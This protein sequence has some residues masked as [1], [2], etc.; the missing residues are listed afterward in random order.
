MDSLNGIKGGNHKKV[1]N[2]L[3]EKFESLFRKYYEEKINEF[4]TSYPDQ[5]SLFVKFSDIDN[6]NQD[7]ADL[8]LKEPDKVLEVA[9]EALR[10]FDIPSGATLDKA[11]VRIIDLPMKVKIRDI[12]SEDIGKLISVEG[13]VLKATEV[14]PRM[15]E[16]V[17]ECPFCGHIFS[18]GQNGRQFKEPLECEQESGGCGRKVQRF[19]LHVEKSK[20]IDAQKIRLQDSPEEL[21]GGELP[22]YIDIN[23]E[24]DLAG[25][26]F[27]GNHV[28]VVGIL[29]SHQRITQFGRTPFFDI[30]LDANSL[31]KE[32]TGFEE[33]NITEEDEK[34]ILE[35]SKQP[36]IYDELI[37]SI[38]P[39]IQG[40]E[41][42]KQAIL[43]QLFSG[44]PKKLPD[45][46]RLRG[47]IHIILIGDPGL[48]KSILIS[49]VVSEL[50]PRGIYAVGTSSSGV[51]LTAA[52]VR[53][54]EFGG[55]SW[56]LEAGTLVLA[57]K[58][59]AAV[60]E[61]EKLKPEDREKLHEALEQQSVTISKAGIN[62]KLNARCALLAAANPKNGRFDKYTAIGEQIGISP[63]LLSRF[64]LIFT[65]MDRPNEEV[66]SKTTSHIIRLHKAGE[67]IAAH[68]EDVDGIIK[69]FQPEIEPSLF[70]KYVAYAKK[71]VIP[72]LSDEAEEKIRSFYMGLRQQGY[73][74]EDAPVP[75]TARQL[76]ALIRLGEAKARTRLSNEITAEDAECVINLVS[77]CLKRVFVDPETDKLDVDWITV[78][79]T[80]TRRDRA[81]SIRDIIKEL[82]KEYGGEVPIEEI[83]DLA[84]KKGIERRKAEETIEMMKR[85][86]LLI[87][88]KGG[89]KYIA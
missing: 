22:E 53:D 70:R 85:D 77:Y 66:D 28:S 69:N 42:E 50:A 39:S 20:Y 33:I 59:I 80:K 36:D 73:E 47:N 56:T 37:K 61:F 65:M 6:Y 54:S 81:R 48:A 24:G 87:S 31:E 27:P 26:V 62:A 75:V 51:G 63:V 3:G 19:K 5:C 45:N 83:L 41:E 84:E 43:L 58:G 2:Y 55:G 76:E 34:E 86:G 15:V 30:Y 60:D 12:R 89:V 64:D 29:R 44:V 57:D 46:T 21:R 8:L 78:G 35:L 23:V 72:I 38:A 79:T 40:Y 49:Y 68:R 14:R 7:L 17:F 74:D 9:T 25:K 13:L 16:A 10:E 11:N 32:D 82:E 88:L 71:N 4:G 67:I 1:L 18:M 52:A